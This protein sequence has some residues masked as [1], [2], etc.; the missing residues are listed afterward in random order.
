MHRTT[1]GKEKEGPPKFKRGEIVFYQNKL[2]YFQPNGS[3]CYLYEKLE[4][5]GD[6]KKSAHAPSRHQ[7]HELTDEQRSFIHQG[8][9]I[10]ER[11]ALGDMSKE[12]EEASPDP[13]P[14]VR[15]AMTPMEAL[16]IYDMAKAEKRRLA[17]EK[18]IKE[19]FPFGRIESSTQ[20]Y[21]Y[22]SMAC[23]LAIFMWWWPSQ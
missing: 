16:A 10:D 7:V 18:R 4:D 19:L 20:I 23:F 3:S 2:F 21:V 11:E 8:L 1:K 22:A 14:P 5:V 15:P 9:S 13:L 12:D 6:T 17:D